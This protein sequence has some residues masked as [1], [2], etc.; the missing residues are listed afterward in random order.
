M[1]NPEPYYQDESTTILCGDCRTVLSSLPSESVNCCVTSPPYWGLRSYLPDGV[2]LKK[3]V[4]A[5]VLEELKSLEIV[6]IDRTGV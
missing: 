2:V 1:T 6:P 3:D 5:S 4:P